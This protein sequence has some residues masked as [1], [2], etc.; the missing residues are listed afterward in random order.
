[1]RKFALGRGNLNSPRFQLV[2]PMIAR[3][4]RWKLDGANGSRERYRSIARSCEAI[5]TILPICDNHTIGFTRRTF[6]LDN[7]LCAAA[8]LWHHIPFN[9]HPTTGCLVVLLLCCFISCPIWNESDSSN[10]LFFSKNN[11]VV[12]IHLC[13]WINI[14]SRMSS[15]H[16]FAFFWC[17]SKRRSRRCNEWFRWF[18]MVIM[19]PMTCV[20]QIKLERWHLQGEKRYLNNTLWKLDI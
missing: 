8:T 5:T 6:Q 12:N 17:E 14:R 9:T 7:A 15:L 1:M 16:T 3:Q 20:R 13:G 18:L 19:T 10:I 4:E 11:S 2:A